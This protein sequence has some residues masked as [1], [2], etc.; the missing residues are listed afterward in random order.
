MAFYGHGCVEHKMFT[1]TISTAVSCLE[2]CRYGVRH[3][4]INHYST[5]AGV[6]GAEVKN[7]LTLTLR[8][9]EV[10]DKAFQIVGFIYSYL[11]I[12]I[13]LKTLSGQIASG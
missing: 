8:G 9:A 7:L 11:Y 6:G 5:V 2:Y 4:P 12:H 13:E 10:K 1:F 3:K